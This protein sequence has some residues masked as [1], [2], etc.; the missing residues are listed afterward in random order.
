MPVPC[1][2]RTKPAPLRSELNSSNALSTVTVTRTY[3]YTQ[4]QKHTHSACIHLFTCIYMYVHVHAQHT[5]IDCTVHIHLHV[6]RC[7]ALGVSLSCCL[8]ND[9]HFALAY[10]TTTVN[11]WCTCLSSFYTV[12]PHNL[13]KVTS[14]SVGSAGQYHSARGCAL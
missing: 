7:T 4:I 3:M 13:V 10:A 12:E 2:I 11:N 8:H 14:P 6:Y 5:H 9:R 1:S